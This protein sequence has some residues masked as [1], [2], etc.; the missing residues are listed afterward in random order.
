MCLYV[1]NKL[2]LKIWK[3]EKNLLSNEKSYFRTIL[4]FPVYKVNSTVV[5]LS[6]RRY[7]KQLFNK[8]WL[9][10]ISSSYKYC[11]CPFNIK[12]QKGLYLYFY[13]DGVGGVSP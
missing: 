1:S 8:W 5:I 2:Q 4:I 7:G 3:D 6:N 12:L 9:N 10:S 13:I 11:I